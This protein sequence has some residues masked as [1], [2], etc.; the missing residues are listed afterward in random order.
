MIRIS[1]LILNCVLN[2]SWQIL[3]IAAV[4]AAGSFLLKDAPARCRH[5]LWI[6][7]LLLSVVVPVLSSTRLISSVIPDVQLT[8]SKTNELA[9]PAMVGAPVVTGRLAEDLT[10]DHLQRSRR[11]R[12]N[13]TPRNILLLAAI[14]IL[15]LSYRV[16]RV[17]RLW[18]RN[19]KLRKSATSEGLPSA[20]ESVVASCGATFGLKN[21]LIRCSNSAQVP[22]TMGMR[23]PLIILPKAFCVNGQEE[24]LRSVIGHEMAHVSRSD[25]LSNLIC[26]ILSLPIS[27]HPLTFL[28]KRQIDRARELAC[29]ELV[30]KHVL[31]RQAYARSLVWAANVS[32]E[33]GPGLAL[34]IFDGNI[35]EERVMK[36]MRKNR[37]LNARARRAIMAAALGS[38]FVA[39]LSFSTFSFDISARAGSEVAQSITETFT[40]SRA[41]AQN[42]PVIQTRPEKRLDSPSPEERAQAAC[43]AGRSGTVEE[44]P[45]LLRM[46]GDDSKTTLLRCWETARWNPALETFKHASPGEQ[47]AI[48]LASMGRIA[49]APLA[50]Q[51]ENSN[52]TVR[53]NAAW[54]IGELTNMPPHERAPAVPQLISLLSDSDPWVRMAAARALGEL[55]DDRAGDSLIIGLSDSDWRVRQLAAWALSEMKESRAVQ[56]LCNALLSDSQME[57]RRTAAEALGEIK[58]AEALPFLKQALS[59]PE[60]RVRA[61]V[62]WAISEIED[63]DG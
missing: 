8:E 28:I 33:A 24:V 25:Y 49:F 59:D 14:Y 35:L 15:F 46:L 48:A 40:A 23:R 1:E 16:V 27:F 62:G 51:L 10:V 50:N 63:D 44:I 6:A 18:R 26:E 32:L 17:V 4:A 11:P 13:T 42:N 58:N 29:D 43:A 41:I 36:L 34:S 3:A 30:T 12:V 31:D 57:V 19:A 2:S 38:L 7:A 5:T 37:Q 55:R 9:P 21:V 60:A 47:A 45:A 53:R 52:A 61:K 56:S 22:S 54:A 20:L 39:A